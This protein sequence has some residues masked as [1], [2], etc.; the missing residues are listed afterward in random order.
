M[1]AWC[2]IP[3]RVERVFGEFERVFSSATKAQERQFGVTGSA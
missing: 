3:L 1:V 2:C